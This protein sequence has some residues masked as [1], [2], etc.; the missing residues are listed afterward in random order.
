MHSNIAFW[1]TDPH[2]HPP[3]QVKVG[4]STVTRIAPSYPS[5]GDVEKA[6][7]IV[8]LCVKLAAAEKLYGDR[9]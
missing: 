1:T 3:L 9:I 8:C 6:M 5:I 4:F 7:P 2:K